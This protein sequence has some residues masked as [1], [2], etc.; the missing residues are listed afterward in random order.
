MARKNAERELDNFSPAPLSLRNWRQIAWEQVSADALICPR[1]AYVFGF[2]IASNGDGDADGIVYDGQNAG[3]SKHIHLYT[4]D[5]LTFAYTWFPP[6]FFAVGIYIDVGTNVE[7]IGIQYLP[8][9][10]L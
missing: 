9:P 1:P 6:L 4:L 5:E 8:E 2:W 3:V 7:Q 10:V